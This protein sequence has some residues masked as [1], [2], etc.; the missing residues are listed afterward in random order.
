MKTK[1]VLILTTL[2]ALVFFS[3]KEN[4]N[5]KDTV[6]TKENSV[7]PDLEAKKA[8]L[9]SYYSDLIE[10]ELDRKFAESENGEINEKEMIENLVL[11]TEY[12]CAY[13][14]SGC[15]GRAVC[16]VSL[17]WAETFGSGSWAGEGGGG[18]QEVNHQ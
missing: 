2:C 12:G 6:V 9:L 16:G 18:C 7:N 3:F 8:V 15:S 4:R 1:N 13:S 5:V 10:S 11:L 14:G 17:L